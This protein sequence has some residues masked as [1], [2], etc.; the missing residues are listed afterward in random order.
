MSLPRLALLG[1]LVA[2]S[3]APAFAASK[4]CDAAALAP[5]VK[6]QEGLPPAVAATRLK[7]MQAAVKCDYAALEKLTKPAGSDFSYTFGMPEGPAKFWRAEGA[8]ADIVKIFATRPAKS[9][10]GYI[11]PSAYAKDHPNERDWRDLK[12]LFD[13]ETLRIFRKEGYMGLRTMI[14]AKGVWRYCIAGD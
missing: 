1:A 10:G 8:A 13:E 4:G 9:E 6:P 11:W 5:L 3:A 12:G 2:L 14:D 7:I